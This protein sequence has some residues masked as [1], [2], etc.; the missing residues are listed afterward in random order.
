MKNEVGLIP[1]HSFLREEFIMETRCRELAELFA[2]WLENGRISELSFRRPEGEPFVIFEAWSAATTLPGPPE[3]QS[4][5]ERLPPGTTGTILPAQAERIK[6]TAEHLAAMSRLRKAG[7]L[8]SPLNEDREDP[9]LP[10]YWEEREKP[11]EGPFPEYEER[12]VEYFA[13]QLRRNQF[14]DLRLMKGPCHSCNRERETAAFEAFSTP[15]EVWFPV[16]D[17]P[18]F[19]GIPAA[20]GQSIIERARKR[21]ASPPEGEPRA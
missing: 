9:D 2:S 6:A 5:E 10:E 13:S 1:S 19:S 14:S 15:G 3:L 18:P 20:R 17:Q 4:L 11:R 8:A 21:A 12:A 16:P 7:A